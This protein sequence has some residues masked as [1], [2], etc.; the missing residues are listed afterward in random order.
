MLPNGD[1]IAIIE[2]HSGSSHVLATGTALPLQLWHSESVPGQDAYFSEILAPDGS[3]LAKSTS[4]VVNWSQPLSVQVTEFTSDGS[5]SGSP[6]HEYYLSMSVNGD[7][8]THLARR[9]PETL[10]SFRAT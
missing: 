1:R 2:D 6:E 3:V 4:V 5:H 8:L 7:N 9:S 10:I